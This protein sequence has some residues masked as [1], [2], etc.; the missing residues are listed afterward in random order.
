MT[1]SIDIVSCDKTMG[2]NLVSCLS[3]SECSSKCLRSK[4]LDCLSG[5]YMQCAR[6]RKGRMWLEWHYWRRMREWP[7][8]LLWW[9]CFRGACMFLWAARFKP[10]S[11]LGGRQ[12]LVLHHSQ[13]YVLNVFICHKITSDWLKYQPTQMHVNVVDR[14]HSSICYQHFVYKFIFSFKCFGQ[15]Y[16]SCKASPP[17]AW[18]WTASVLQL[19][20]HNMFMDCD[21]LLL[22]WTRLSNACIPFQASAAI[23]WKLSFDNTEKLQSW[24]LLQFIFY[25]GLQINAVLRDLT[26]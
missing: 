5:R 12:L 14:M 9:Q 26:V 10:I 11:T 15:L 3:E 23:V 16:A 7:R 19:E 21:C 1:A 22:Y 25:C 4:E 18:I 17:L 20:F 13:I 24:D 6:V 2:I 8:M